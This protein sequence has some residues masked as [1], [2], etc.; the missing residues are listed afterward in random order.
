[1]TEAKKLPIIQVRDRGFSVSIFE[2][3]T[4]DLSTGYTSRSYGV[5]VQR[6]F[7][8]KDSTEWTREQMNMFPEDLLKISAL[9]INTYNQ[10]IAHTNSLKKE[11]G[12]SQNFPSAF[13]SDD[14]PAPELLDD[15]IP[16]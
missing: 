6:S 16:F 4:K 9:C 2:R 7:K 11:G 12:E 3:I 5:C 13:M 8:K 15:D 14:S 10:I 1:M